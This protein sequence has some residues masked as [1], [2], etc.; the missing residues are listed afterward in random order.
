VA[1]IFSSLREF[2][3]EYGSR[4][5]L[6]DNTALLSDQA[7]RSALLEQYGSVVEPYDPSLGEKIYNFAY[8]AL[9]GNTATGLQKQRVQRWAGYP[10][11]IIDQTALAGITDY[12]QAMQDYARGDALSG[13]TNLAMAATSFIPGQQRQAVDEV[14]KRITDGSFGRTLIPFRSPISPQ[15]DVPQIPF[16]ANAPMQS[17]P[18]T[19]NTLGGIR[20]LTE[21]EYIKLINPS[22]MRIEE[23]ARPNLLMGDMYGMLPRDS[24]YLR[25]VD[26]EG[27]GSAKIY[28][29]GGDVYA[30]GYNPDVGEQDVIGY[31]TSRGNGSELAVA[32]ELQGKGLGGEL[33]YE[34]R[35]RNP[36]AL[37]G[38]LTQAGE[39]TARSAYRRM[40]GDLEPPA[41]GQSALN[42]LDMSYD[43]RMQR[44]VDQGFGPDTYYKGMYPYDYTKEAGNYP[45]PEITEINRPTE[46]PAFNQGEEGVNIAGFLTKD[47]EIANRF[48]ELMGGGAVYPLKYRVG[49]VYTIDANGR[50]AGELQ[51]GES[52]QEFRDAVRSG[53]YDTVEIINTADEGDITIAIKPE[54]IRSEYA[55]FDPSPDTPVQVRSALRN[56]TDA[57]AQGQS[58]IPEQ[59]RIQTN[60]GGDQSPLQGLGSIIDPNTGRPFDD[61]YAVGV[62]GVN[63]RANVLPKLDAFSR[64]VEGSQANA[65][66]VSLVDYLGRPYMTHMSDR[67]DAQTILRG[68]NGIEFR[69]P[70]GLQGGQDFMFNDYGLAW[71]GGGGHP[72]SYMRVADQLRKDTGENPLW[73]PW[74]MAPKGSDFSGMT[75][76][77]MMEYSATNMSPGQKRTLNSQ[78]K[79]VIPGF[80]NV[81]DMAMRELWIRLD[82]ATRKKGLAVM[83]KMRDAGGISVSEA[84]LAIADPR[85]TNAPDW[86][87][88]NVGEIN[89]SGV[90]MPS[91]HRTYPKGIPGKG[92]GVLKERNQFNALDLVDDQ[93]QARGK[94]YMSLIKGKPTLQSNALMYGNVMSGI[95][96]EDLLKRLGL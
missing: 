74:R 54:N 2:V 18:E 1:E 85:Q 96:T 30:T 86:G 14:I 22:G 33:S 58:A 93:L 90:L 39:R 91:Q 40:V 87:L 27:F 49:N 72:T 53:K 84:R 77:V 17:I 41:Q 95:I 10:Q 38:G 45:G 16:R 21:D 24:K 79:E 94:D 44:A 25:D 12:S 4:G 47:R 8:D 76:E 82:T 13:T 68:I 35:S 89:A 43:T 56:L 42:D 75:G 46:F 15:T 88:Q 50:K 61:R 67:T 37:S 83:D 73:L 32:G 71:A 36:M 19:G 52:G 23:S 6:T 7:Q 5:S 3:P 65:P 57:P 48:A 9:G 69:E 29:S 31:M 63:P 62:S 81:D 28:E 34:F 20:G 60:L 80:T 92:L 59:P 51:F 78:L 64:Q 55:A 26:I 70:I 11:K 66:E